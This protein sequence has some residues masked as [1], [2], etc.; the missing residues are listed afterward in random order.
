M[1]AARIRAG[2]FSLIASSAIAAVAIAAS[3]GVIAVAGQPP[4]A[5]LHAVWDGAFGGRP[6]F[7][8]TLEKMI[9]LSLVA[10]GWIVAF[11][12]RRIN[13]GATSGPKA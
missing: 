7:G 10:L 11:R 13:I 1:S 5:A 3:I 4:G 12:A 6:Q 2:A 8:E 9:P